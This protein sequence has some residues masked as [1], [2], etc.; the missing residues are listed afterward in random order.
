[1]TEQLQ[2]SM[3]G[4]Q[5]AGLNTAEFCG[6]PPGLLHVHLNMLISRPSMLLQSHVLHDRY[7]AAQKASSRFV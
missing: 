7:H 5:S 2:P 3:P 1:M 6:M 4:W